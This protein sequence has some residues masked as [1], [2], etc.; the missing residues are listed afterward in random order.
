MS[1]RTYASLADEIPTEIVVSAEAFERLLRALEAP[2]QD[3]PAIRKLFR[4]PTVLE[5]ELAD[6]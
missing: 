4:E 2:P 5:A 6:E 3:N 1:K